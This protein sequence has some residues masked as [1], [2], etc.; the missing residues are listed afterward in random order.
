MRPLPPCA[1]Q[2]TGP[3]GALDRDAHDGAEE[4]SEVSLHRSRQQQAALRASAAVQSTGG[5]WGAAL[6]AGRQPG[7]EGGGQSLFS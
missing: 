1:M 7:A 4:A 5:A 6:G 2:P 3:A